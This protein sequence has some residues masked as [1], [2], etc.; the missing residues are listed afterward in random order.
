VYL[1]VGTTF[2][3]ALT[4]GTAAAHGNGPVLLVETNR[5]PAVIAE[6]LTRLQ[7][8][9]IV[10]LGGTDAISDTV[11]GQAG[12]HT[13][14]PVIRLAGADRFGTAAALSAA[15]FD[16]GA[17]VV[18]VATGRGFADSLAAATL[19]GPLLLVDRDTIPAVTAAELARLQGTRIVVLGGPAVVS[20]AVVAA[21]GEFTDGTVTRLAG[22]DR[23]ATSVAMSSVFEPG[24]P[25]LYLASGADFAD[26][27]AAGPVA[28]FTDGPLLLTQPTCVPQVVLDEIERLRPERIVLG[29]GST[30]LGDTVADLLPCG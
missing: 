2:A 23:Y 27:L 12:Q 10:I 5:I 26:G 24:V 8:A 6:E 15:T 22:L 19:G 16:P 17:D 11:F 18:Y 29:G 21:L 3:D 7:P 9:R 4:G 30:A 28:A 1:A 25:V 14:G 13:D 20:D